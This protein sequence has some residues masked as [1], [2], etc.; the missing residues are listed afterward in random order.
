MTGFLLR[1][2]TAEQHHRAETS[3]LSDTGR[4]KVQ[5]L[6]PPG[7]HRGRSPMSQCVLTVAAV[8]ACTCHTKNRCGGIHKVVPK[9]AGIPLKVS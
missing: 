1:Y 7:V 9:R 6:F 5:S 4:G 8:D 3:C 2:V